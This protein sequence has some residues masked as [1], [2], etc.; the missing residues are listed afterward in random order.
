MNSAL[1][2]L[3]ATQSIFASQPDA[4]FSPHFAKFD[5]YAAEGQK[6]FGV[7]GLTYI[8]IKD[9]T[10][11]T[12]VVG[13]ICIDAASWPVD[14]MPLTKWS[15]PKKGDRTVGAICLHDCV[16]RRIEQP[17]NC[18]QMH[19][20]MGTFDGV[21]VLEPQTAR[22]I[23][24]PRTIIPFRREMPTAQTMG[25]TFYAQGLLHSIADN[26]SVIW[27]NGSTTGCKAIMG[28]SPELNAGI[29]VL[30]NLG[31][32]NLPEAMMYRWM[33][34]AAG[35]PDQ[36]YITE[37]M[38]FQNM[39]AFQPPKPAEN[40]RP[41]MD[42]ELYTGTFESDLAGEV[43]VV[44]VDGELRLRMAPAFH[45]VVLQSWD[46]DTFPVRI[47]GFGDENESF[48]F[49]TFIIGPDGKPD[50]FVFEIMKSG[51]ADLML[52]KN[53]RSLF[54][55]GVPLRPTLWFRWLR[56]RDKL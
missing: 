26:Y 49:V 41:P 52:R 42:L 23:H 54:P 16:V 30:S 40:P 13:S 3:L 56:R 19:M 5:E 25:R 17:A 36:D 2:C 51:G 27:H 6:V 8:L 34:M 9:G 50:A 22:F 4:S 38:E 39:T 24:E 33:D 29:V 14:V 53:Y 12:E 11:F 35:L 18:L 21:K 48:D 43:E 46:R 32:N 7:P 47:P 55:L 15:R 1:L 31:A 45:R 20:N 37:F 10:I 44:L 28:F